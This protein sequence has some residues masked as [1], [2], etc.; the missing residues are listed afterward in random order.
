[1]PAHSLTRDEII[2][3][4]RVANYQS[5]KYQGFS[6]VLVVVNESAKSKAKL[7]MDYLKEIPW[8]VKVANCLDDA[9]K[10]LKSASLK[11]EN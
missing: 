8:D 1:M 4:A 2:D 10:L 3:F 7:L 9:I 5:Q 11:L 6:V